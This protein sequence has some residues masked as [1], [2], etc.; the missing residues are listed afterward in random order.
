LR[1]TGTARGAAIPIRTFSPMTASTE[2][3]ISSPIMML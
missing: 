1:K 2:T 3:S